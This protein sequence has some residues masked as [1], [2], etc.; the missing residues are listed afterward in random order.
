MTNKLKVPSYKIKHACFLFVCLL[1]LTA[2]LLASFFYS[3]LFFRAALAA[4]GRSQAGSQSDLQLLDYATT[5]VTPDPSCICNLH[6]SS[7]HQIL[8]PRSEARDPIPILMDINRIRY[9]PNHKGN[10][11]YVLIEEKV[12]I[13]VGLEQQRDSTKS[14]GEV[15]GSSKGTNTL[16]REEKYESIRD[17]SAC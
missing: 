8:N 7:Q 16:K 6:V 14:Q 12:D 1:P 13:W 2:A 11:A 4:Y 9:L 15:R 10:S 17:H 5:T 3:F